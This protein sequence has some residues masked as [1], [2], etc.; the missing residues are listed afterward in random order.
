MKKI[1]VLI[2]DDIYDFLQRSAKDCNISI[3][4][5]VR[6]ILR[7]AMENALNKDKNETYIKKKILEFERVLEDVSALDKGEISRNFKLKDEFFK[8][9]ERLKRS[10]F[11]RG[12][13]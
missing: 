13:S 8:E 7:N 9:I 5:E 4:K 12:E 1:T 3:S 10:Y 6:D 2:D 11:K